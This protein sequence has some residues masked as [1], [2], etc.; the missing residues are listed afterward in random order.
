MMISCN[1]AARLI[2]DSLE[3]RLSI[4]ERLQLKVHLAMCKLCL[5]YSRAL[6]RVKEILTEPF[7][8]EPEDLPTRLSDDAR[9]RI[10][11]V[12]E[13]ADRGD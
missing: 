11:A 13:K 8:D 10:V 3:R 6:H 1:Q 5:S 9:S 12:L 4:G 2:S 7:E